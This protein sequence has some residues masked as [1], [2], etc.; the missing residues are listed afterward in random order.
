[1]LRNV[2]VGRYK[3]ETKVHNIDKL[4]IHSIMYSACL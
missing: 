4:I 3:R 1:M 2:N